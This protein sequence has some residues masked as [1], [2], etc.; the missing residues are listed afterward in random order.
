MSGRAVQ[1]GTQHGPSDPKGL[2]RPDRAL[3][4]I[5]NERAKPREV[6]LTAESVAYSCKNRTSGEGCDGNGQLSSKVDVSHETSAKDGPQ[7][8]PGM[9]GEA[10]AVGFSH[11]MSSTKMAVQASSAAN[12]WLRSCIGRFAPEISSKRWRSR[13]AVQTAPEESGSARPW[14]TGP[15]VS[16]NVPKQVN[17]YG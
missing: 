15:T 10:P 7:A 9:R 4:S 16:A 13:P 8:V 6:K 5:R 11:E 12:W 14:V 1:V 17:S 3:L 2:S